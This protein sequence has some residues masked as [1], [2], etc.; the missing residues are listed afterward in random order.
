MAHFDPDY[1]ALAKPGGPVRDDTFKMSDFDTVHAE[2]AKP[3]VTLK[4][5][6]E[7][8]V[9]QCQTNG[10][11]FY[12]ETQFRRYYHQFARVHKATIRLEHKPALSMEVDWAGTK[13][14]FFDA[15]TGKMAEASLFVAVLP[16]SQLIYAEPFRDEKQASWI[17]GHV[18]AFE[19]FG[20]VPKTLV[21][22]NLKTGVRRPNFYDP[23][24]NKT[25]QEMAGHYG[26][27]IL[28]ARVRK[29]KDKSS[30]ENSVLIASRKILA[31]LRNT[32]ILC[33]ADLQ[34]L[35]RDG[36]ERVNEA[37]LTGKSESRWSSYL[38]EEKDYMLP[39]PNPPG[40]VGESQGAAE[41]P[42][43]LSAQ[44]LLSS[45]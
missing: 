13:V 14:A 28:P 22:D 6:W 24:L 21:P 36:L 33:F 27:V 11:R 25:Y 16:C 26:T 10:E 1:P 4:L 3:H 41:L 7:E 29:P 34:K 2:L 40:S 19:Y 9:E 39:L 38:A 5:L 37:P 23:D 32:Q 43:C 30:S 20:G 45:L 31:K 12:M 8:Y 42:H 15:E 18:H 35:I 44:I 17:A